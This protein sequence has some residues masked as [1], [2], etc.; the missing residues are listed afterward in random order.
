M[1]EKRKLQIKAQIYSTHRIYHLIRILSD[2]G[3]DFLNKSRKYYLRLLK[4]EICWIYCYPKSSVNYFLMLFPVNEMFKYIESNEKQRPLTIRYNNLKKNPVITKKNLEKKGLQIF[5]LNKPLD[6]AGI[7]LKNKLKIGNIPEYLGGYYTLQS[8]ASLMPVISL[9]PKKGDRVLDIA[10]AP[11]GKSTHISELMNN[12]GILVANDKNKT[13]INSLV[14]SIHRLGITNCIVTNLDG[15]ILPFLLS[16]FDRV[17]VD[18]P[19]S[20]LGVLRRRPSQR[21]ALNE[22]EVLYELPLLQLEI[23]QNASQYVFDLNS[24]TCV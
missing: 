5:N 12:T 21:W 3:F 20:S 11:G 8:I 19:C 15:S 22:N 23:L 16:G 7:I 24:A 13:R 4:K 9:G 18:A 2:N 1:D 6:M 10:A 17:L 14:S